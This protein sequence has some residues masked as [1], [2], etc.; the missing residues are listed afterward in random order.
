MTDFNQTKYINE[1]QKENKK[2]FRID[3]NK[4]E[5]E[6][7]EELLKKNNLTKVGFVRLALKK[8]EDGTLL[9]KEEK[10]N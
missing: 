10:D 3:L 4:T 8:L 7:A 9:K 6:R 2:Q 1:W 5:F